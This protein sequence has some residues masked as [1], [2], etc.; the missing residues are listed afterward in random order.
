MSSALLNLLSTVALWCGQPTH[1]V[2]I[3][4][5]VVITRPPSAVQECRQRVFECAV[6][7]KGVDCFTGE[8]IK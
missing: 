3:G 2:L 6:K 8:K 5:D 7:Q 1:P 4:T